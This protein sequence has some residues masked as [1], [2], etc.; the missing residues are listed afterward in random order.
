VK[1]MTHT[2]GRLSNASVVPKEMLLGEL[3]KSVEQL[4]RV[5]GRKSITSA[6]TAKALST[7]RELVWSLEEPTESDSPD[8]TAHRIEHRVS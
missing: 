8:V 7:I 2:M 6:Q 5:T 4:L 1:N 3:L